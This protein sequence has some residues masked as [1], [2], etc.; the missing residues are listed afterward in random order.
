MLRMN[1][2]YR[3]FKR[4]EVKE[5]CDSFSVEDYYFEITQ[6]I[7]KYWTNDNQNFIWDE[8]LLTLNFITLKYNCKVF[9]ILHRFKYEQVRNI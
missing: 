2:E 3:I 7:F 1:G 4:D 9:D 8:D 6:P 5:L